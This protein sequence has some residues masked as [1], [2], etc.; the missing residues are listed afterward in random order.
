M[1][2]ASIVHVFYVCVYTY[3]ITQI[4]CTH[5]CD[6]SLRV[7][8]LMT[9]SHVHILMTQWRVCMCRTQLCDFEQSLLTHATSSVENVLK[10]TLRIR[11]WES[12]WMTAHTQPHTHS[13]SSSIS[14]SIEYIRPCTDFNKHTHTQAWRQEKTREPGRSHSA[15]ISGLASV[16][17]SD[18]RIHTLAVFHVQAPHT[19][20]AAATRH[21]GYSSARLSSCSGA[22][23]R[24]A[25]RQD[26]SRG[27]KTFIQTHIHMH[28]II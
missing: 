22:G 23:C 1:V 5:I 27:M 9:Q 19:A 3:A 13:H 7:H 24:C 6:D 8:I 26:I 14:F 20:A 12:I 10:C 11:T 21:S 4:T 17:R 18:S 25:E 15:G 2:K 28:I 16:P